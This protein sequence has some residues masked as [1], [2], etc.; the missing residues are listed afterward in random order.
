MQ[1]LKLQWSIARNGHAVVYHGHTYCSCELID[2]GLTDPALRYG[3]ADRNSYKDV[4]CLLPRHRAILVR[5]CGPCYGTEVKKVG[6][7]SI[8][9]PVLYG[10]PP[11]ARD[12]PNEGS[13]YI[14][15]TGSAADLAPTI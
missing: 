11:F 3:A 9:L 12:L 2:L 15:K 7:A 8:A 1:S 13:N 10:I 5:E 4:S 6:S 14:S